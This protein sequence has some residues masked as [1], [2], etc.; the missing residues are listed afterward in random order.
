MARF[1]AVGQ[2]RAVQSGDLLFREGDAGYD[3]FAIETGS[4]AVVQGY[5]AENRLIVTH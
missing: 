1:R 2:V 3:F 4:V 5:G